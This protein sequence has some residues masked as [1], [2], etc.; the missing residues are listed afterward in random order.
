MLNTYLLILRAFLPLSVTNCATLCFI[1]QYR[2]QKKEAQT[3]HLSLRRVK[4]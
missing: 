4:G 1:E 2:A 3:A